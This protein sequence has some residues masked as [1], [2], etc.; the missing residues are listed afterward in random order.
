M[1]EIVFEKD[2]KKRSDDFKR[3]FLFKEPLRLI[4]R[5]FESSREYI[6]GLSEI[7]R[8]Y[9][10]E[11]I[12]IFSYIKI[13]Y[14]ELIILIQSTIHELL[15]SE[16]NVSYLLDEIFNEDHE[17]KKTEEYYFQ[18]YCE[19]IL[20]KDNFQYSS[21]HFAIMKLFAFS[22]IDHVRNIHENIEVG[23]YIDT[24]SDPY[25]LNKLLNGWSSESY[26]IRRKQSNLIA[27]ISDDEFAIEMKNEINQDSLLKLF[28]YYDKREPNNQR[29]IIIMEYLVSMMMEDKIEGDT[30]IQ[31]DIFV[32]RVIRHLLNASSI[33][34]K[35]KYTKQ[36]IDMENISIG[37]KLTVIDVYIENDN[38]PLAPYL[39]KYFLH[40]KRDFMRRYIENKQDIYM[41]E[42]IPIYSCYQLWDGDY[43]NHDLIAYIRDIVRNNLEK[44]P[45]IVRKLIGGLGDIHEIGE[46]D[47]FNHN[48]TLKR[49]REND[50]LIPFDELISIAKSVDDGSDFAY[51]R[52]I[53]F[54]E[55]NGQMFITNVKYND[56]EDD[57]IHY[58]VN[59]FNERFYAFSNIDANTA[60]DSLKEI[61]YR[62][63][64]S[65]ICLKD[66]KELIETVIDRYH[67]IVWAAKPFTAK[68][69]PSFNG[70]LNNL[71]FNN[72]KEI[73]DKIIDKIISFNYKAS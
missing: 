48:L 18:K 71:S 42:S 54:W 57:T 21:D 31:K 37:A 65:K 51:S 50:I 10:A 19:K 72:K 55:K 16:L 44:Y 27:E 9:Q 15:S 36:L 24:S 47:S 70:E 33:K 32:R 12:I 46:D 23:K 66:L 28:K 41:Y 3:N 20:G 5:V 69:Y 4:N 7:D 45:N 67:D 53:T 34:N 52:A 49:I 40:V 1:Q 6:N 29:A 26:E 35:M 59:Y 22:Y 39:D 56:F 25:I 14:P 58:R 38:Y 2:P 11:D 63:I 61:L 17:D 43:N 64:E 30:I 68:L 8:I 13:R 73:V 62:L 60:P